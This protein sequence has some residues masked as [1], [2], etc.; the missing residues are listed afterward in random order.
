MKT[1]AEMRDA[2]VD[3]LNEML[4][5]LRK[6]QFKLRMERANGVLEKK[7]RIREIKINIAQVKTIMS[8]KVKAL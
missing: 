6:G 8:E 2:T 4:L 1:I 5:D 3:E 7:H